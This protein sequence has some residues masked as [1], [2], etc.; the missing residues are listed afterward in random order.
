[1]TN[2]LNKYS[3]K[4]VKDIIG[5]DLEKQKIY[6]WLDNYKLDKDTPSILVLT[7]SHGI[8]KTLCAKLISK[9]KNYSI[10]D[11]NLF[12]S[13]N[14]KDTLNLIED[15]NKSTNILNKI[16]N[17]SNEK[18]LLLINDSDTISNNKSNGKNSNKQLLTL[19]ENNDKYRH[20]PIIL[21]SNGQ[22]SKFILDIKKFCNTV[23]FK[24]PSNSNI[25]A[26]L[27]NICTN[28]KINMDLNVKTKIIEFSQNDF[29]R[30]INI[31]E[32][33]YNSVND[34]SNITINDINVRSVSSD[35]GLIRLTIEAEKGIIQ[36]VR[37][38]IITVDE[39]DPTSIV[40]T[41][42]TV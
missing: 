22:Y 19:F 20:F 30:L 3:P 16:N 15:I 32:D 39:T 28:E 26:M 29:R 35:D 6:N 38:T 1:M 2:W 8:G 34:K 40:T 41:L 23:Y 5:N 9:E 4:Y 27:N 11:I 10:L 21:I 17:K 18:Y 31:V 25:M 12:N 42:E 7:G 37:N 14:Q 24:T 13:K 33:I 36:S